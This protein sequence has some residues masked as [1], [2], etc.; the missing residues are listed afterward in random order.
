MR[1]NHLFDAFSVCGI[2]FAETRPTWPASEC[3]AKTPL[4]LT[5][6]AAGE[7]TP[8]GPSKVDPFLSHFFR[9]TQQAREIAAVLRQRPALSGA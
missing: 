6:L 3:F 1:K 2:R 5:E 7:Q 8:F 9:D 4:Q